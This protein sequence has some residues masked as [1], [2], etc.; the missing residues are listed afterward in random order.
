MNQHPS[1]PEEEA[2]V[3][4]RASPSSEV[5]AELADQNRRAQRAAAEAAV[6]PWVAAAEAAQQPIDASV[7]AVAA[8]HASAATEAAARRSA[9]E[10][11]A[12]QLVMARGA[13]VVA[14]ARGQPPSQGPALRAETSPAPPFDPLGLSPCR[15]RAVARTASSHR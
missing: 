7:V 5:R 4:H 9:P 6:P 13:A 11:A 3:A 2:A 15:N 1:V 8:A 10:G 12:A 14:V